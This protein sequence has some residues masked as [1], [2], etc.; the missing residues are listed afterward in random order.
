[1]KFE[2]SE[3][4]SNKMEKKMYFIPCSPKRNAILVEVGE[5]SSQSKQVKEEKS[6]V[7]EITARI[8]DVKIK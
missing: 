2:R 1:M 8:L 5:Y 4:E 6:D 3:L 7:F